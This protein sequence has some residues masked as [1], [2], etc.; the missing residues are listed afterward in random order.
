MSDSEESF[1]LKSILTD[2]QKRLALLET[3]GVD[4]KPNTEEEGVKN[5]AT[6]TASEQTTNNTD[7]LHSDTTCS[8]LKSGKL[9]TTEEQEGDVSQT[10]HQQYDQQ[11]QELEIQKEYQCIRDSLSRVTLDPA[12]RLCEGPCPVGASNKVE[13]AN[14]FSLTYRYQ[15]PTHST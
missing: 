4:N 8:E 14:Y 1:D 3:K 2:I 5:D 6:S 12:L 15:L 7:Q 13:R 10:F 9:K 11:D